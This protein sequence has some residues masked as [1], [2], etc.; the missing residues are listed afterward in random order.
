MARVLVTGGAGYVGRFVVRE[1][2]RREHEVVV[3][4]DL[5]N[6]N[7]TSIP[8]NVELIQM[9]AANTDYWERRVKGLDA[10][11]HLA[12]LAYVGESLKYPA[13]YWENNFGVTKRIADW[14][15]ANK[16]PIVFASSCSVYGNGYG[17]GPVSPY[18][19]T[20]R[21]CEELLLDYAAAYDLRYAALR[22]YNVAGAGDGIGEDHDPE[23]HLIPNAL[24]AVNTGERLQ[25]YDDWQTTERDY[26][27]VKDVAEV[28]CSAA[29]HLILGGRFSVIDVSSGIGSTVFDVLQ[30]CEC[31]CGKT[32]I[33]TKSHDRRSGDA[34]SI[35]GPG[36]NPFGVQ[37]SR[38]RLSNIVE[39]AWEWHKNA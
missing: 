16:V 37:M 12:A 39:S 28:F 33:V 32:V 7:R 30:A 38:S 1:L 22:L 3:L 18:G 11:I 10:V 17:V 35:I 34:T 19:R 6:G 4:D 26:V 5:R 9:D 15:V 21:A 8:M 2:L 29:S 31:C 36:G 24:I 23:P 14:C 25:I 20:K 27:H 13:Y